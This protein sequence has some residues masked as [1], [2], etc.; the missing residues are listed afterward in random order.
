M[1]PHL[2]PAARTQK[3]VIKTSYIRDWQKELHNRTTQY[4]FK[5]AKILM[6]LLP[7]MKTGRS[8]SSE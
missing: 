8:T 1:N 4:L 7:L 5:N 6:K 3:S 2:Y